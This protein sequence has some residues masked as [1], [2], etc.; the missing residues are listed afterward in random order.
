MRAMTYS[1]FQVSVPARMLRDAQRIV[2]ERELHLDVADLIC[3]GVRRLV[4]QLAD[5]PPSNAWST[6]QKHLPRYHEKV[7]RIMVR[8]P[9]GLRDAAEAVEG[10][11]RDSVVIAGMSLA[12]RLYDLSDDA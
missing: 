1:H 3:D 9:P 2:S 12:L 8:M 10:V 5:R 4:A 7:V 11:D 6:V